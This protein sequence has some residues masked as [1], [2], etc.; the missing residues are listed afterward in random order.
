MN[1][2]VDGRH[3]DADTEEWVFAAWTADA[4]L[5]VISGHRLVGRTAWYWAAL[6]RAGRPLLHVTDF[7]VPVRAVDPF[8]VKGEQLWAEHTRDAPMEQWSIG[9]ETYASALDV[10]EDALGLAYGDPTPIAFDLEWYAT[11]G[12][13]A[14]GDLGGAGDGYEQPGVVHGRVE[15]AGEAGIELAEVPAHRW[16]RWKRGPGFG[17]VVLAEVVAHTGVRAP[18][19]FPDGAATD[20][21]LTPAGWRRRGR[22][23]SLH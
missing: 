4:T 6:A 2:F 12:P 19:T 13:A 11:G 23:Q 18:F 21:V 17:P 20:L 8:I 10:P 5:G 22:R 7:D 14:L 3:P 1:R 15:I 9:N 16:H